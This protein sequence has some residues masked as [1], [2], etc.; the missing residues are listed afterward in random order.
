MREIKFRGKSIKTEKRIYGSLVI[1]KE[2]KNYQI[3]DKTLYGK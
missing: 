1:N 3:I 2:I